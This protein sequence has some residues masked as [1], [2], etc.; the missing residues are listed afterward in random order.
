MSMLE[1]EQ[2]FPFSIDQLPAIQALFPLSS[3]KT[4]DETYFDTP[5]F[6]L[7]KN[8][9]WL[10]Q[11]N[12]AYELK[13]RKPE[14]RGQQLEIYDEFYEINSIKQFLHVPEELELGQW[15]ENNLQSTIKIKTTRH[16]FKSAPF[17]IDIDLTD[18]GYSVC[19][20]EYAGEK[21]PE[22]AQAEII[23][24]AQ[25]MGLENTRVRNKG[26]AYI[27]IKYPELVNQLEELGVL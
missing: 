15:I 17:T 1:I 14:N 25:K 12:G 6:S 27:E 16:T 10:R 18:F 8:D 2:Q 19:E 24:L 23:Q 5:N 22:E 21:S 4:L 26:K 20:I 13:Y 11:R 9:T 7:L 3:I